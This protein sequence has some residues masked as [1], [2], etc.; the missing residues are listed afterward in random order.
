MTFKKF[1]PLGRNC[2]TIRSRL[3]PTLST[4]VTANWKHFLEV[5]CDW[6]ST[7]VTAKCPAAQSKKTD[8]QKVFLKKKKQ[9]YYFI[10]FFCPL[11]KN[12]VEFGPTI[13]IPMFAEKKQSSRLV[14]S[15]TAF[16]LITVFCSPLWKRLLSS[17][18]YYWPDVLLPQCL[19]KA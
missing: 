5:I 7:Y 2:Y 19:V 15:N 1:N 17:S 4:Q 12:L 6:G 9:L 13:I 8:P 14:I 18:Y 11:L 3:L 10:H 16:V